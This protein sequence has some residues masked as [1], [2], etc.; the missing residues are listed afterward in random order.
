MRLR[1]VYL[2]FVAITLNG[3]VR[4]SDPGASS[5]TGPQEA[6]PM[7]LHSG[8]QVLVLGIGRISFTND[9]PALMLKYQTEL[10]IDDKESLRREV[11]E[12]WEQFKADVE[13]QGLT[14]AIIRANEPASGSLIKRNRTF[15]YI[16][17]KTASGKWEME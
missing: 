5:F 9:S 7:K 10:S 14:Q 8:K 11:E 4:M 3:C 2:L 16:F 13:K 1:P 6:R 15:N 12:I 17:K